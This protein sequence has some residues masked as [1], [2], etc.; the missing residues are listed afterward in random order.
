M[1]I[2]PGEWWENKGE[3]QERLWKK[4]NAAVATIKQKSVQK[5]ND[6]PLKPH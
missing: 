1:R 4:K 6:P 3:R 2:F 5:R